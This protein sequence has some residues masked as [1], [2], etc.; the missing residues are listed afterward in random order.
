MEDWQDMPGYWERCSWCRDWVDNPPV[1]GTFL[2]CVWCREWHTTHVA[3]DRV[4]FDRAGHMRRRLGAGPWYFDWYLRSRPGRARALIRYW[5]GFPV[6]PVDA[7]QLLL[8]GHF[9]RVRTQY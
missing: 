4:F 1:H 2:L 5:T 3:P 9:V 6:E 7:I 8:V